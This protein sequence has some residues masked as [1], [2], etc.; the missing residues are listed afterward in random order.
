MPKK[1]T[2]RKIKKRLNKQKTL[3]KI[4]NKYKKRGGK[5]VAI[6]DYFD[7]A[8][9]SIPVFNKKNIKIIDPD[10]NNKYQ[11]DENNINNTYENNNSPTLTSSSSNKLWNKRKNNTNQ[12]MENIVSEI[13]NS[14]N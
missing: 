7:N 14:S 8:S 9:V 2:F 13:Q 11:P 4:R 12:T 3:K 6:K 5:R 1:N 10:E